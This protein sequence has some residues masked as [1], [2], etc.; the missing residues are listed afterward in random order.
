MRRF[1][2]YKEYDFDSLSLKLRSFLLT[3]W[4][5]IPILDRWIWGQL[6]PP[7]VFAIAAFT[8]VSLSVGVM[9]ELVRK[10]VESGLPI[11]SALQILVL[12]LPSFLVI[13]FPMA[14]LMS[15]LITYSRLST[16]SELKALRSIGISTTRMIIP[17]LILG[18]FMTGLTFIFNDSIVPSSN[19]NAEYIFRTSLGK[20][21]A[22]EKGKDIIYSKKAL[23]SSV[24][25]KG[26]THLFYAKEFNEGEMIDVTVLDYSVPNST[27]ILLAKKANWNE[28]KQK[29]EFKKGNILYFVEIKDGSVTNLKFDKHLYKLDSG[30]KRIGE[31]PKDANEMTV[32]E[33]LIAEK[34]Y[35]EVGN[36][37]EARRIRVRIQEKFTL[38][39]ACI[40]FCLIGASLG[41]KPNLQTNISQGFGL[42]VVLIFF[43][44]ALS[45]FFS[46]LGVKGAL[47]PLFA[48]WSPV[49][50][51]LFCGVFLLREASR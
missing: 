27:Q 30:P 48:A 10:I 49:I 47:I 18:L 25:S 14:M 51:S 15:S 6:L 5:R 37:K 31:L 23:N 3:S 17:A 12:R 20:S 19:R 4:K 8:V 1:L 9:F 33:A 13:S 35:K 50:I 29:W 32:K 24:N 11:Q 28:P 2:S 22:S 38:P 44:Y 46:A 34:L 7:L 40:V 26:L 21:I 42:S 16:N 36:I 43:Y 45:F 39:I 41:A